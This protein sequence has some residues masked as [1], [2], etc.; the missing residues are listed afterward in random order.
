MA[1]LIFKIE[2]ASSAGRKAG[3]RG[4]SPIEIV[5]QHNQKIYKKTIENTDEILSTLDILLKSAKLNL[6]SLK[7]IVMETHKE[8]GLTSTRIIKSIIKALKFDS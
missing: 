8:A 4:R 7:S 6:E 2:S 1:K 3:G 5:L